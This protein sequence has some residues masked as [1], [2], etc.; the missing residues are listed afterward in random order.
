MSKEELKKWENKFKF[1]IMMHPELCHDPDSNIYGIVCEKC[2]FKEVDDGCIDK[3]T[4][5]YNF[6]TKK[7]YNSESND[8]NGDIMCIEWIKNV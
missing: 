5:M 3:A 2:R 4:L 6:K 1:Y 8:I 7:C